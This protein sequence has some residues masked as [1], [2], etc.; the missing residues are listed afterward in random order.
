MVLSS[1]RDRRT[2]AVVTREKVWVGG[3]AEGEREERDKECDEGETHPSA[4]KEG[5]K[6]GD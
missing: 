6:R 1:R 2:L 4:W 5:K 3:N